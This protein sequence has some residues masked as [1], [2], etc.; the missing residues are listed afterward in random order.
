MTIIT[1]E[2]KTTMP[3]PVEQLFAWHETL[4]S[5]FNKLIPPGEPVKIIHHDGNVKD[6]ARAVIKA[7][8][9]P[10]SFRWELQHEDYIQNKQFCDRQVRGPFKS[11][12]HLH[13]M[14][15]LYENESILLDRVEFEMPFGP[16]GVMIGRL[17]ILPKLKKLFDYR[18]TVTKN[19]IA[20]S[21]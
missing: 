7:G 1:L 19:D 17:A 2:K 5:A 21:S 9:G 3:C 10:F 11:W 13:L 20:E 8:I 16:I 18:H 14:T 4:P 12:H 6:G 15:P